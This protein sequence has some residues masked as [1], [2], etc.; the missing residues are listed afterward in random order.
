MGELFAGQ[1]AKAIRTKLNTETLISQA[2]PFCLL[3]RRTLREL[4]WSRLPFAIVLEGY[5]Q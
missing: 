3:L 5:T 2:F 1:V 4:P